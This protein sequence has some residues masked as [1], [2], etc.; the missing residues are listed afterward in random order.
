MRDNDFSSPIKVL[1]ADDHTMFRQ[2]LASVLATYGGIEVAAQTNND[3]RAVALAREHKP[4]VVIMQVQ[5]PL[6]RAKDFLE[7][8]RSVSPPP[9]VVICTMFE[10]PRYVREFLSLGVTA[11][12]VKSASADSSSPPC[13][14]PPWIPRGST[15]WWACPVRCSSRRRRG[16]RAV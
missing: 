11:Y 16:P 15:W 2:G 5:L 7:Q 3:E 4:D 14:S 13:A 1:L 12:L 6:E 9:R 10:D 8:I